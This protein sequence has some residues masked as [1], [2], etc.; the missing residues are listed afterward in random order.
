MYEHIQSS[1]F[2]QVNFNT[3]VRQ[4]PNSNIKIWDMHYLRIITSKII[5]ISMVNFR[6]TVNMGKL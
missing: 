2:D 6:N 3:K 5:V 1:Y 4:Q